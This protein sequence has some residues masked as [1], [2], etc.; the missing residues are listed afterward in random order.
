MARITVEDCLKRIDNQFDLV[1]TAAKRARRIA[2]GADPLVELEDDKPTV[3]ALREIA[4]GLIDESILTEMDEPIE[5]ILSSEEAEELL[6]STPM[7]SSENNAMPATDFKAAASAFDARAQS[8]AATPAASADE[9]DAELL[10]AVQAAIGDAAPAEEVAAV[11]APVE[12]VPVIAAEP[13]AEASPAIEV[14]TDTPA[15]E[16]PADDSAA[17][18]DA[19]AADDAAPAESQDKDPL[20]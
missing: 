12:E 19:P 16:A 4:A 7:P 9:I 18:T 20:A 10:A 3:V 11:E 15:E 1:M 17:A 6:A 14:A 2:N 8:E 5:D 13:V